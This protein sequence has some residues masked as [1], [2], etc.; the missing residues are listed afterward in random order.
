M[1]YLELLNAPQREAVE[2]TEGPLLILAG[3]GSGKTRVLT[4]RIAYLIQKMGVSPWNILAITFTNKAAGEMRERVDAAVGGA[5]G[6]VWV[7]T[8]HSTCCR[9]LRRHIDRI[10]YD[11]SFTIYD[12][13]D[14]RQVIREVVKALEFDPK[15][16]K[17]RAVL[18]KISG[19][20][21]AM[22]SAEAFAAS[23]SLWEEQRL[24]EIY[25]AYQKRLKQNNA[26][27]FD[28]LLIK[29]V[30]L[31][32]A[33]PDVLAEYQERFR[34]ILV[35]EYQ[36]TN[37]VQF[38]LVRML[39]ARYQNLCVV[40]D[41]DQ[42]IY[43]FR[44]ADIRN[45]LSFEE[46]FP[47]AH[48]VRLEQNYR[49][50][51]GILNAANE[52]I[53][54]NK[55][56]RRKKLWTDLGEGEKA[57]FFAF[58]TGA[59]EAVFVIDEIAQK[60]EEGKSYS[61][62]AVLYRTNAQSRL[63]EERCVNRNIPYQLVGGVNFY[64]RKE[65]KDILAYLKT[66]DNGADDLA[67]TRIINV[68]KRAIG[69][70][71]IA[72]VA[73]HA[74]ER[75]CSFFDA[76]LDAGEIPGIGR[77]TKGITGFTNQIRRY[78]AAS[79]E[80]K[81]VRQLIELILDDTGYVRELRE[82]GTDEALA[83]IENLEELISKAEDYQKATEEPSL[84]DFLQQVSLVADIDSVDENA[85]RLLLMTMHGA[86]GLEFENVYLTGLEENTFP[87]YLCVVSGNE[88]EI[89][90]ERRLCY[91]GM[92]RA[93][94]HLTLT[95]ANTRM[96]RGETRYLAV[97]RFVDE[98]PA[99][100]LELGRDTTD[101]RRFLGRGRERAGSYARGEDAAYTGGTPIAPRRQNSPQETMRI[102]G[103]ST[104]GQNVLKKR[105][106]A[107]QLKDFRVVKADKLDYD[108]GDRVRH[109]KFGEGTVTDIKDATKDF[110]VTVDFDKVGT[111]RMFAS[112]AKLKKC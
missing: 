9:I 83:R 54:N 11:R 35:D 15:M 84:S 78:R 102:S 75:G 33:A 67:V 50:T 112:F 29:T 52:V 37:L 62:F 45:I 107:L 77:A 61:D 79:E 66:I 51:G 88:E 76:L 42:S 48:V 73:R 91:V 103:R 20:K 49:S 21:N 30:E 8:F 80:Y 58:P 2:K 72:R 5:A 17:D 64:S 81:S 95:A 25:E 14:S 41:D 39:A 22:L 111:K 40:G 32:R 97:S 93:K 28:D 110:E 85:D 55:G 82:E 27:D 105:P 92:T 10:G 100:L 53:A 23:A 47:G 46:S 63:F 34:Y 65:I 44:G 90:E 89:E 1:D 71:S 59:E 56:R 19:A 36:D 7:S 94:R 13:D 109:I 87:S 104:A 6:Q 31:F 60:V 18:A 43:R 98:I 86:K 16:Y 74:Q 99:E 24:A 12:T 26:L 68:P 101:T 69:Q 57:R 106:Q 70:T 38:E 96:L 3:A 108:V 4:C